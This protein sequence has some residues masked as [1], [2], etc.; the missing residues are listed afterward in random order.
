MD[1]P[2]FMSQ[3]RYSKLHNA[4]SIG[5]FILEFC[6]GTTAILTIPRLSHHTEHFAKF[7][8]VEKHELVVS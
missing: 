1:L 4:E 8:R 7:P 2:K 5:L 3:S 6:I